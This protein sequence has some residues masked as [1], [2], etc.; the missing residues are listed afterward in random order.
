MLLKL[1]IKTYKY[2]DSGLLIFLEI[3]I[4]T[5]ILIEKQTTCIANNIFKK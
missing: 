4:N 5:K 1:T 2:H 3:F